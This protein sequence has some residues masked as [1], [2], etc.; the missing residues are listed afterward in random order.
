MLL[1]TIGSVL[2]TLPVW[3]PSYPQ[4][5]DLPQHAAQVALLRSLRLPQFPYASL[6]QVNWFTPYLSAYIP[7]DLLAR[8]LGVVLAC[9]LV[10]AC[11]VAALPVSTAVL[12]RESG[13]DPYWAW[14]A[15]PAMYGYSY[16]TQ[17]QIHLK[18]LLIL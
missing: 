3:L 2:A 9:K 17:Y 1:L 4:M 14:L 6:F 15:L 16:A 11:A 7:I 18:Y 8:F 10:V 13:A 5:A 12:M